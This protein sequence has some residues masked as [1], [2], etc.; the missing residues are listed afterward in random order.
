ML[1]EFATKYLHNGKPGFGLTG[2]LILLSLQDWVVALKMYG[3]KVK[4][5]GNV[6]HYVKDK[7]F[8][9]I[10]VYKISL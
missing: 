1:Q 4:S 7:N 9:Q 6:V 8:I 10:Q 3:I 2:N 5:T